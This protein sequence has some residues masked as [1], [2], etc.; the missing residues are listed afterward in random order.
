MRLWICREY[1]RGSQAKNAGIATLLRGFLPK[2]RGDR[3]G[4]DE[5]EGFLE[6]P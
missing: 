6:V 5:G 4:K 1:R 2:K 3:R